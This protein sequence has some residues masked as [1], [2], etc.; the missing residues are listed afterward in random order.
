MSNLGI[1]LVNKPKGKT[2]FHLVGAL[3]RITKIQKIGHCGTLDPLATGVMVMLIGKQY[4]KLSDQFL[5]QDKEYRA[6]LKLGKRTDSFDSEGSLLSTSDYIPHL[7]EVENAILQFQGTF[8]Q[9]PPMFSAKKVGGKKLYELARKGIA[10]ERKPCQV[11][12][13]VE[14]ISYEYPTVILHVH[15]SKGTY[16]RSLAED[17]G[18]LLTCGAHLSDLMRTRSGSFHLSDCIDGNLLFDSSP[19]HL[20][21][22]IPQLNT[23]PIQN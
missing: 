8:F 14:L 7:S 11:E 6:T 19:P 13:Q 18:N 15:C 3:R 22:L 1:L 20:Q 5:G 23:S 21:F 17:I 9:T 2:S 10:I 12:A 16:I 4:T